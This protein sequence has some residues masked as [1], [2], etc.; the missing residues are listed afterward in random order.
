[1]TDLAPHLSTFLR[2]YLT[3]VRHFSRHTVQSYT[4]CFRLLVLYVA[5]RMSCRPCKLK[6][7][8]FSA[9]LVT[10][11]LESL[12]TQRNNSVS[13]RNIRLAAIKSFFHYLECREPICLEISLQIQAIPQKRTDKP[14]IDWLDSNE[15]QAILDAP[16][17]AAVFGLRDRAM[18]HLCYAAGL[19]VSELTTLTLDC[20]PNPR[21]E[22]VRISGK[23]RR[24]RELPL[25]KQT[26]DVLQSWLQVRPVP[27]HCFVFFNTKGHALS[28]DGF[29][30]ILNKHVATATQ[31]CR[32]LSAKRITPHVLRH[33]SAMAVLHSTGDIRK[34]SLW[35]GHSSIKSTEAYLRTSP[36]E[37]LEILKATAP[38]SIKPGNFVGVEDDLMK[39][40]NGG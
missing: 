8:H 21:M 4:D 23:G 1:M 38:P 5:E 19:R 37:K 27:N 33:S 2:Q 3:E 17:T 18:L 26:Q 7:E 6:I 30:Y 9:T 12:Q 20:F 40:L 25:W 31:T 10:D 15:M 14:L 36:A 32:S 24:E 35:L 39:L 22:T 29:T 34:V 16:D 28:T 11:F 13:T